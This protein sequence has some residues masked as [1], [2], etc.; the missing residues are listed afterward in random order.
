MDIP[1]IKLFTFFYF[2]IDQVLEDPRGNFTEGETKE[3]KI[4][5]VKCTYSRLEMDSNSKNERG[6]IAITVCIIQALFL[7]LKEKKLF[8]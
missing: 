6:I 3:V 2:S 8:G 7:G 5:F 4:K 1:K